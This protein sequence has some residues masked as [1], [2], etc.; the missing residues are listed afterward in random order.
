MLSRQNTAIRDGCYP[1]PLNAE[2][3]TRV[4]FASTFDAA[5]PTETT[6]PRKGYK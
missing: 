4:H 2:S 5:V 3:P 6:L 1:S